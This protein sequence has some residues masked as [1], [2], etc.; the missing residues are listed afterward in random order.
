MSAASAIV[1]LASMVT[2]EH[3]KAFLA[4]VDELFRVAED[5]GLDINLEVSRKQPKK[6]PTKRA[7]KST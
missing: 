2:P 6:P 5:A 4:A 1:I 3:S 7:R